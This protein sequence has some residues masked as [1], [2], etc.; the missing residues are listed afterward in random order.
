MTH[1]RFWLA[2][3]VLVGLVVWTSA[4]QPPKKPADPP[5]AD[6]KDD[7][8]AEEAKEKA[9]A[10]RFRKVLETNPRRGTAL[11]RLYG[12]HVERGTLDK[13]VAEYAG[14]IQKDAKDGTA[15]MIVGLLESQRGKDAAA[16][17]AFRKAEENLPTNAIPAWYLGQSLVLLGQPDAAAEAFERAIT[18]RPNRND[19]LDIFQALGRVYQRAQ[20]PEKALDVWNRLEKLYPD[21]ARVQEQITTTLVEEGDYA[22]ALPRLEKLAAATDDKYRQS[23]LR[24]DLA[25]LK[26][27]LKRSPEAIA[28]F[29]KLL[30]ELNPDSWLHRDVR[31]RIEDVFLR[32]DDLAGLAKYYEKWLEK[33][34]ADVD[35]IARLAKNL[36]SQGRTPEARKWLEEGIK[37][38]PTNRALRQ[39]LIDQFVFEQNFAAAA[40]QYEAMDKNDPNNPDIL[41]E[42]GKLVMRDA[43]RPEADRRAAA[44]AIWKRMLDKKPNDPVTTSQVAD[45]MRTANATDDAIALYKKAIELAPDAAQYREYLGEYYHSLKRSDEALATWRPIAEGGN[46]NAKNLAR[47]AEVFAGFGY[48]KEAIGAMADAVAIDKDDFSL[49]MTYAQL[50]HDDGQHDGA[51]KQIDAASKRTSN[52]EEVE[53][54]LIAQIKVFQAT[55]K[56]ADRI[57]ELAKELDARKDATADRWLRMARYYEA[58]RQADRAAEAIGKASE[59]D[60]KSIPVLI[61][62]ARIYEVAGNLLAA[63]DTNRKLAALDRRYRSE[64]LQAVVKQE[65]RL[66]RRAEA[67]QAGRDLLAASPGNPEVYKFFADL[68]FQLGDQ[69]EGLE[70]LR[71]SVRANPS[72]PQGLITLANALSERVRQGEAI[73]LLWRAFEK[74][75]ELDAKLGVIERITQLYLEN[76]QF[77]RLLE[78]LERERRE[79]DK[80]RE[81]TMCLAQAYTTAGDLGTARQQLERLLTENTRDVNLLGQLVALCES[82]GDIAAAVKYQRQINAAAPNSY[83]HSLKLAQLL[84]RTG[85]AD[86]AADIWVRLV[87]GETEPH[88]NLQAIDNLLTSGKTDAALAILSRMLAQKPGNWELLYREAAV[89]ATKGKH[90]DAA[91][92]FGAIMSMKLQDDEQGEIAKNQVKQAKKKAAAAKGGPQPFNPYTRLDESTYPPLSRRTGNSGRVRNAVGMESRNYYY[93]PGQGP[94][95][96]YAPGDYGEARMACL[97]WLYEQARAKN[98]HDA[99][100]KRLKDAKDKAGA[101]LRP[102]WDWYYFQLLRTDGGTNKDVV[103]TAFA[104]SKG[105]DPAG[106]LA[107]LNTLGNRPGRT[108]GRRM[109][110]DGAKDTTPPL[111]PDQLA[112]AL[113]CFEKLKRTK[114]DWVRTGGVIGTLMVELKR[115]GRDD[116]EA[117]LYK[118]MVKDATTLDKVQSTL[119][120]ASERNDLDAVIDL[121]GRME[122]LQPPVKTA[123]TLGQLPTR[124]VSYQLVQVMGKRVDEKKYADALKVLDLYLSTVR[125]QNLTAPKSASTSR[126]PQSGGMQVSMYTKNP[127]YGRGDGRVT[128]PSPNEYYDEGSITLLYNAFDLYKKADLLSDLFAHLRKQFDAAQGAEKLY[129]QLALGY[130]HWWAEEKDEAIGMLTGAVAAAPADHN[131]LMEVANLREQNNEP[132]AALALLDSITPLD[133]QVM[134]RREDSALRLAERTGNVDRARQAAERLFGLRL[135]ADKQL[136]LAGK[137]HRLGMAQLAETVLNRA[138]RQA[139]NKTQVLVRL[140][141]QYQSQNQTD[142]AVTIARQILRKGPSVNFDPRRYRGDDGD[143]GRSQAIGVLARSGQL[144]EMIERAEAQ[145][146]ASPRSVQIL[147]SLVGYYQAAGDKEKL[148]AT[149]VQMAQ[150]RPDDGKLRFTVA[151]QLQQAGERDAAIAEYKAAIKL[152]PASF[153]NRYWEVQNLFAQANKYDELAQLMDEIDL[154]KISN[155]WSV[156]E[157]VSNLMRQ[158]KGKDLGLKLFKKAWE[159]FPQN[160]GYLLGRLYDESVWR[161]PEIYAYAKE[162]VIPREDSD[163]DPWSSATEVVSWGQEGRMDGVLNRMMQIARKQ[164]RL[165]EL[166]AEVVAALAR[167]PDWIGGKAVLAVIEVQLGNKEAGKKLWNEVFSDPKA[168]VPAL[169]RFCL[170]QELEFYAGM[171]ETAVTTLE[172]GIDEM[173]RDGQHQ[174]DSNPARRLIWWY[175][176]L[177]RKDDAKKLMLRFAKTE[178]TNPG[179]GGGYYQYQI[180]SNK[181]GA[182]QELTRTGDAVEAVRLLNA[183]LADRDTIEQA[184]QYYSEPFEQQI[185]RALQQA[186]KSIKPA[187]LPGA[188]GALLTP[189][190]AGEAGATVLDL[191]V[192]FESRDIPRAALNS[193]FATAIKSTEKAPA[194]RADALAK[195]GELSKKHP[196][197]VS[198]L[199]A[200]ALAALADGRPEATR[201]AVERLAKWAEANPLEAVPAGGKPNARQRSAAQPQMVLWLVA[202]ECLGKGTD[203]EPLRAAGERLAERALAAARRQQDVLYAAAVLREWGQLDH[204]RGDKAKAE[205]RWSEVLEL[206]LPKPSAKPAATPTTAVPPPATAVPAAP[207]AVP[208]P[209]TSQTERRT[210]TVFAAANGQA[211]APAPPAKATPAP[212]GRATV[213]VLSSEQFQQAY[214][215][216]VMAADKGTPALSLRAM[217]EAT[218]GGPPTPPQRDRYRGGRGFRQTTIGGVQ[219]LVQDGDENFI[220][221]D[222]ALVTLVPK[223]RA[224]GVPAAQMYGVLVGAILPESRPAEVFLYTEGRP[225]GMMYRQVAGMWTQVDDALSETGEDRGLCGLVCELAI[226]AGKVDDLRGRAEARTKQPLGELPAKILLATLAVRSKDDARAVAMF[227]ALGE[228]IQKDSLQDT[229]DRVTAVLMAALPNEKYAD[230]VIP[231]VVKAAENFATN[232]NIHRTVELR[233]KL[234]ARSLA[235]KDEA[236]A[237]AQFKAVEALAKKGGGRGEYDVHVPLAQAYLKAGWTD[238]ALRE[239]GLHADAI[240]AEAA[241]PRVRR[242]RSEPTLNE[243]PLLVR[244]LLDVPAAKRYEVLKAWSLPTAGRKSIRYY[245]GHTPRDIPPALFGKYPAVPRD[246][247]TSTVL[248]LVEAAKECGKAD[249]LAAAADKFA[250]EKVENAEMFQVLVKL[251]VGQGKQAE[252]AV[253]A[254][255]EA[256]RKRMTE[257]PERNLSP[258]YYDEEYENRRPRSAHP[259]EVLF[260]GMCLADPALVAHG[261][262]LLRHCMDRAQATQDTGT[263]RRVRVMWDRLGATRAGAP[264]ALANAVPPR[265]V[266]MTP[267][268]MWFAQDGYLAQGWNEQASFL[269][270]DTPL[271]GTFEFSV[272]V[273]QGGWS[274]GHA[275]YAGVVY[276]PNRGSVQS[277]VWAVGNYDQVHR[278]AENLRGDSFNRMTFQVSPEKVRCL[279]NGQLYYEDTDPQPTSPWLMLYASTGRRPVFR[280]FT[281]TGNPTVL[282]EV[283]LTAGDSLGGWLPHLYG[284]NLPARMAKREQ[285]KGEHRDRWGNPVDD[286]EPKKVDLKY[287]WEAKDGEVRGRKLDRAGERVVPSKLAYFRPLRPGESVRYEFLYE[288]GQT[289]VHPSLGRIAF[290][291]EPDGVK[292]HWLTDPGDDNWTGLKPDN[293]VVDAAG[294]KADTLPLKAGDWNALTLSTTA[295]GVKIELNGAVVYE[296]PLPAEVER[297]FGLFHY[298]DKTAVRVRNAVLTGPWPKAVGSAD[299]VALTAKPA[300]PAEAKARRWQLGERFYFTEAGDVAER[301]KK[302]P[303][304]ERYKVLAAWVLPTDTR[305][306]FQI[307]GVV[308]PLDVLGVVDQKSQPEGKRVV[309]GFRLDAPCLEMVAAAKEAGALDD[310]AERIGKIETGN[311]DLL[312]RSKVALLAVVHAAQGRDEPAAD[313][314]RQLT[315]ALKTMKPD[316]NPAERWPDLIAAL[317][318][319]DHPALVKPVTEL[320]EAMNQNLNQSFLQ[321]M[322]FDTRDWWTRAY[323]SIR[324]RAQVAGLPEGVRRPFGTDGNFAHWSSVPGIEASGRSQGWGVPHWSYQNGTVTHYPGHNEDYL[325][326]RSP[327]KGDFEVT[328]DLRVQGWSEAHVRYGAFQ[329]DL[330]HDRKSYRMHTSVRHNARPTTITPPLPAGKTQVYKFRM[331]VKDGWLRVFVDDR[332]LH[333]EKVGANPDPWLILHAFHQNTA[334]VVNLAINGTP[335]IPDKVDMLSSDD[336]ALWRAYLGGVGNRNRGGDEGSW[337]RRGE[338]LYESGKQPEPPDEGKP[339]PPR[340]YPESALYYQRPLLEDGAVEYEFYYDPGKAAVHPMLDRLVFLLEPDGVKLH[341]LTDGAQDKSGVAFDNATDEPTCRRGPA[342]LPL[343]EKAWNKVRLSVS[344]DTVKLALN[345]TE[346]YERVVEPTNQRFF[347]LFHYTDRTEARVRTMTLSGDWPKALPPKDKLFEKK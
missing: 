73:E 126:R 45:L 334:P 251:A 233:L 121:F 31:R 13:L 108:P 62:A 125:R 23:T 65:Q 77:D 162:A 14:R 244:Q 168:D 20:R 299:E 107:F 303:P 238:D 312:R 120:V 285:A 188:V 329:F 153:S 272:D 98:G 39:A 331:Q 50:L 97:G 311:D 211:A 156:I 69:E 190:E 5:A 130:V 35:A 335:T 152:D 154:R 49:L 197:D 51:L 279:L 291:L 32:N 129:L 346:V 231:F 320:A 3:T 142:L 247:V 95:P 102:V 256:A 223:W 180:V 226:E 298:R 275:G 38:A 201:D 264:D 167:R 178:R 133:T 313:G 259:S 60:P 338:E 229:N 147:Q 330:N 36:S 44:A 205:A 92:R 230:V 196:A 219:Y 186:M 243:F 79:A 112:H 48:R 300:S 283:K 132:E 183:L 287:D 248:L 187:H 332:E 220:T 157:L 170:V 179:Y 15:W 28:D 234:A 316:A 173:I 215:V 63:A 218:R 135:D 155:Y 91:T 277:H 42:W 111:P 68:C 7:P 249:E 252:P 166:K 105:T 33:N 131:L 96:F 138:Q 267:G 21:D 101:D 269:L 292:L 282:S 149:L 333:A 302:L 34:K 17:A 273:W 327:L 81:M 344:G 189:R 139:G 66:G 325:V 19:L 286:D 137:M 232:N 181:M 99:F 193:V 119:G 240:T 74:T 274:E 340:R 237:R 268:A 347:G 151:Q 169:A 174:Y 221:V 53:Q 141:T 192:V 22:Q 161:L 206:V 100:V 241:D 281:I 72:D 198:V 64:Y 235:R 200:T 216:A 213:P 6:E 123:S 242:N 315:A 176:Q 210:D 270:L 165:P 222:Q 11:D 118:A 209:P 71:R 43:A 26:V 61:A 84:T 326:F 319:L 345:G 341:W 336:L 185:E 52:P 29:E 58:N 86:E 207:V 245:V 278:E 10:E 257:Q 83:D 46:R 172:A 67:L 328:C 309:L 263:I 212:A 75:N 116:D 9:V 82:E 342:R 199:T 55:E 228:R 113:D 144:K 322:P 261:E 128:F 146:K 301:A 110:S 260:V 87:A 145:L 208:K 266:S 306:A 37:V 288:P 280:N 8:S 236:A 88:R 1:G 114:P 217:K 104:L 253:K 289:H 18:R 296:A 318:T 317:G 78:R 307:A 305:P 115:A 12:Y 246:Q 148:K 175:E 103:N 262:G 202:R 214:A 224:A 136:E 321:T 90:D 164:Q 163:I 70:A 227:Q 159:A 295:D 2:L 177:G 117:A 308:K 140:M 25:D 59:K 134:Q 54:I 109:A 124:Q 194:V 324:A 56:L 122:Q 239:L 30:A 143:Y 290:L 47:L 93:G 284:G 314:L 250:A 106:H 297:L 57:D 171:E 204:D 276:E 225:L 76:N 89:L 258:D 24:M 184:S 80:A 127:R 255:A 323:R 294:R 158:E 182:A 343:K 265:W 27:K 293:A 304:A 254:F 310:L 271:A 85:E 16:V 339:V 195:L 191:V 41:R 337:L 203:R 40:Q 160:R 150:I 94:P 4:Q